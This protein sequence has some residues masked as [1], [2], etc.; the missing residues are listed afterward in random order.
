MNNYH[1]VKAYSVSKYS[2]L[3]IS[4][5]LADGLKERGITVNAVNPGTVRTKIM[6][7][8]IW[9][10]DFL[11][12]I[13]MAPLYIEPRDG[14]KTCIYLATSDEVKNKTGHLYR[15]CKPVAISKNY[16]NKTA[17]IK[18]LRYYETI[19]DKIK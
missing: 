3:L 17:R 11:I 15:K 9:F 7:T 2:Q 4:L 1:Y 8:N 12:N 19:F 14:A 18:L 16:N 13:L 6:I 10:Y 5:E